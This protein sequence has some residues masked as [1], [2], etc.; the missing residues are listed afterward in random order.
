MALVQGQT[1]VK[2]SSPYAQ[3]NFEKIGD[4]LTFIMVGTSTR[5]SA[6]W[7]E[8]TVAE[9]VGF[10]AKSE[11]VEQAVASAKLLSFALQT[12]MLNQVNNGMIVPGEAYQV[13]FVLDKGDKYIDKKTGKEAK[14]KAKHYKVLRLSL[15]TEAITA[16]RATTPNRS[17]VKSSTPIAVPS[18]VEDE[19]PTIAKPRL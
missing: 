19:A 14:S 10:D 18:P 9:V 8:F 17:L 15:P 11:S 6:E 13:E 5:N 2:G 3:F 7:G 12:V 1:E 16:L 4:S